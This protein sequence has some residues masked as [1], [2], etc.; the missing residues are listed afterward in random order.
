MAGE[1]SEMMRKINVNEAE[2]EIV[3]FDGDN[4]NNDS[5]SCL[6]RTVLSRE[7]TDRPYNFQRMKK[8]LSAAWR[9]RLQPTETEMMKFYFGSV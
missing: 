7:H 1:L 4:G 8:A 9:P 3:V 2:E 5:Q 6:K